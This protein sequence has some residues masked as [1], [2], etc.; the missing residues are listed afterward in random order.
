MEERR[1]FMFELWGYFIILRL[2][3]VGVR[4]GDYE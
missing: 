4:I 2:S 1:G 3:R